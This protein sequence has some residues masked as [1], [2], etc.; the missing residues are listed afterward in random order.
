MILSYRVAG[1]DFVGGLRKALGALIVFSGLAP[2]VIVLTQWLSWKPGDAPL[3]TDPMS[4][5]FSVALVAWGTWVLTSY[6]AVVVD[7]EQKTITWQQWGFWRSWKSTVRNFDHI[8]CI[9]EFH[10][11]SRRVAFAVTHE[12][13]RLRLKDSNRAGDTDVRTTATWLGVPIEAK[14][15]AR[16]AMP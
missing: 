8:R 5:I 16:G 15:V 14:H 13:E 6:D 10:R 12:N 4:L 1:H 2:G 3:P 9:E 7:R 11:P